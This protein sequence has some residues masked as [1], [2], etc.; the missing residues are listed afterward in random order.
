M[1]WFFVKIGFNFYKYDSY[2][3]LDSFVN[4]L[5]KGIGILV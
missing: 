3:I 5:V 4:V 2:F 1:S